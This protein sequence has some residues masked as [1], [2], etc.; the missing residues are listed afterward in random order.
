MERLRT[1]RYNSATGPLWCAR[2]MSDVSCC[3]S[4]L[5]SAHKTDDRS[6]F[7]R[8]SHQL[9]VGFHHGIVDGWTAMKICGWTVTLL[10]D[11]I[12]G[13]PVNNDQLGEHVSPKQTMELLLARKALIEDNPKLIKK[14]TDGT[15]LQQEMKS[16]FQLINQMPKEIEERSLHVERELDV[17]TTKSFIHKCRAERVTV[18]S[19]FTALTGAALTDLLTEKGIVQDT[20]NIRVGHLI[21]MRRYWKGDVSRSLGCHILKPLLQCIDTSRNVLDKFWDFA[22][23]VHQELQRNIEDGTIIEE[24]AFRMI[25]DADIEPDIKSDA[26][27]R[28]D[29]DISNMGDVT[30]L[31]TEGGE[32][33]N[34]T[35]ILRS[36]SIH[37]T[38]ATCSH[39]IHTF[40]GKFI[41][42]LDYNTKYVST[43]IAETFCNKIFN[44][45]LKVI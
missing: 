1:Y 15:N 36:I 24:E 21:N 7:F 6:V 22:R 40:R 10:N 9:F 26:P 8:H 29:Y 34:V 3:Q 5:T 43:E 38:A 35:H 41:Y 45:F 28:T 31:V 44:N 23:S 4:I 42:V 12:S 11:V 37:N 2:L 19:A 17:S 25:N 20:Y 32:H 13:K 18:H 14:L 16:F 39:I 33:I 30:A 27:I